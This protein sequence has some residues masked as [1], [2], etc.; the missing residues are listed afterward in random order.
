MKQLIFALLI[1]G[2][3]SC[4]NDDK[5]KNA[6][7]IDPNTV[8]GAAPVDPNTIKIP[9]ACSMITEAE[10][11]KILGTS[12]PVTLKEAPDPH[13][14][15]AKSCFFKWDD[16][17]TP[18]AGI[19][20]QVL[21]NPVFD[22]YP[23]YIA[24]FVSNKLKDGEMMMGQDTPIKYSEFDADGRPGAYSFQQ[25]RFYWTANNNILFML[26]FNVSTLSERNMKNAAEEIAEIVNENYAKVAN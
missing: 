7:N 22:E 20:V 25:G 12:A 6:T 18:N 14:D 24:T 9:S 26:A 2:S 13:N 21:A 4:K 8:P 5:G 17:N 10:V 16:I 23:E 1:L 15:K 3:L 11:Q 19:L